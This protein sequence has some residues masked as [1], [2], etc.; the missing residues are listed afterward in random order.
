MDRIYKA[1]WE[2]LRAG[3]TVRAAAAVAVGRPLRE[4]SNLFWSQN[5]SHV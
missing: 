3:E 2:A 1:S 5:P 4:S